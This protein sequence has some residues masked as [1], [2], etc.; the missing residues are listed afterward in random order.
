[1]AETQRESY[2]AAKAFSGDYQITVRRIWG[3]PL[4]GKATVEIIRHQGTPQE[5]RQ[6]ETIVFD[7]THTLTMALADGRRTTA[8]YVPPP[9]AQR[10]R[11]TAAAPQASTSALTKLRALADGDYSG[12]GS[13]VRTGLA[14]LGL[15]TPARDPRPGERSPSDVM[16]YQTRLSPLVTS[17]TDFT[18]QASVTADRKYLRLS[19]AP[20]YQT[21]GK[22]GA[23]AVSNP[24][25]PGAADPEASK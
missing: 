18:A 24:F 15:Q 8:E 19:L 12:A 23:P 11:E 1:V 13:T 5:K 10:P 20:V 21:V 4:G 2:V 16:A 9:A 22:G 14:S 17:G 25:I 7:R 3:R 6:R